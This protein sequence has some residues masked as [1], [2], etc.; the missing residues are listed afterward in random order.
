MVPPNATKVLKHFGLLDTLVAK[1]AIQL[2][3]IRFLS[4]DDGE[5][6]LATRGCDQMVKD[7]GAPW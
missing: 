3:G 6:L 1:G 2:D 7:F 4:Y 5:Q